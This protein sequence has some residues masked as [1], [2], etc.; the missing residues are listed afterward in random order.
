MHVLLLGLSERYERNIYFHYV[1]WKINILLVF[2][3][4][5]EKKKMS[6]KEEELVAPVELNIVTVK[7]EHSLYK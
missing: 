3:A 1:L 6:F 7:V 4:K 5:E 2:L